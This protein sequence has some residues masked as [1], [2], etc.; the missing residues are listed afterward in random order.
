MML[1]PGVKSSVRKAVIPAAG[2]GTRLFP[3]TKAVKKEMFPIIDSEGRAKPVILAIAEEALSAGIESVGIVVQPSD[4]DLFENFFKTLPEGDY[5]Q[6]L[7]AKQSGYLEYLR[8][9]GERVAILTQDTQEGFGHAVF[10]AKDWVGDEPFLLLLGDH[11]YKS[12]QEISCAAQMLEA[13]ER[14]GKSVIS[15]EITPATEISHRGCVTGTW[16]EPNVLL[17]V[18]RLVEKPEVKYAVQHLH[19]PGMPPDQLLSIFGMYVLLPQIF[20]SLEEQIR[21]NLR[22]RNEF[23]LTSGLEQ[24]RQELGMMGY[25][26]KGRSFDTG[27]PDAYR[28]ALIEFRQA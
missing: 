14:C 11:V 3:A 9:V 15:L 2:F 1:S 22:D 10:C 16:Q 17:E 5:L 20:D 6:K 13:F 24:L 27:L 26:L 28:Q 25:L 21:Q 19:I 7:A 8:S 12:D 4:R 23:Q 18:T